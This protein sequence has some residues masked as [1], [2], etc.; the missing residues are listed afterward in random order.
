VKDVRLETKEAK[1]THVNGP[2]NVGGNNKYA[3]ATPENSRGPEV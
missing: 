3:G 2:A 1:E